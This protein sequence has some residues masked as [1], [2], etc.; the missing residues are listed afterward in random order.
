MS[1]FFLKGTSEL[2]KG[3]IDL[4]NDTIKCAFMDPAYAPN[5]STDQY[6][7]NISASIASGST[8]QTLASKAVT[9]DTANNRVEFDAA[10]LSIASETIAGG[11]DM[12][13]IYKDTGNVA[14]SPLIA[15][16]DIA[17]G[18]LTPVN[19]TLAVTWNAEGIFAL[20]VS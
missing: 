19:G 3:N 1:A 6:Y 17:E 18:T 20:N 7:N 14:T 9:E 10:D 15:Y 2:M 5:T 8:D 11:T 4:V 13:V 12:M 16:I